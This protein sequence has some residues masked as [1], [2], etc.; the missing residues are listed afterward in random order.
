MLTWVFHFWMSQVNHELHHLFGAENHSSTG[1]FD[2]YH[3][4][5]Y[6]RNYKSNGLRKNYLTLASASFSNV[7]Q[8]TR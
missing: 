4:L 7:L 3:T 1:G 5:Q 2:R 6:A 8:Q